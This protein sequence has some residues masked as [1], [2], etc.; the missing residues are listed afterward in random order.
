MGTYSS[1]SGKSGEVGDLSDAACVL[2]PYG[3]SLC[4]MGW[5]RTE[6]YAAEDYAVF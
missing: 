1:L 4:G 6:G 3:P 5:I 2:S